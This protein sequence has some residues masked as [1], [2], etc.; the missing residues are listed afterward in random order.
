MIKSKRGIEFSFTWL[1]AVIIG[2]VIL[3]LAIYAA[4]K[5]IGSGGAE[6]ST[7]AAKEIGILLNPL[8]T[9]FQQ[10]TTITLGLPTS[11]RIYNGCDNFGNFGNQLIQ[12][13]QK[14]FNKWSEL[15]TEIEF[16]NKYIF[17]DV[18]EE[19]K[20]FHIFSKSFDFPFKVADAIYLT[21][22]DK[23]YCFLN[24]PEDIKKELG[25][26]NQSNLFI[27]DCPEQ[28]V[29]KVCFDSGTSACDIKVRYTLGYVEK[30][31]SRLY[32]ETDALMYAAVFSE[33][34]IY[35]CQVKRFMTRAEELATI[36]EKKASILS[37]R[38]CSTNSDIG[39]FRVLLSNYLDS[40]DLDILLVKS[41]E[42]KQDNE[43]SL[44]KLW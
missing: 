5:I 41:N 22:A 15:S 34:G 37:D 12:T 3:I 35:E 7:A 33:E 43:D 30:N 23:Q 17:S 36:Y 27:D 32:F 8:E 40:H 29:I 18:Y 38:G 42:I 21:S 20:E 2:S 11:T 44:C 19:G 25:D 10:D 26:L 9:G 39:T 4:T 31:E 28:N 24:T 6:T 14:S 1:F 13:S 16:E